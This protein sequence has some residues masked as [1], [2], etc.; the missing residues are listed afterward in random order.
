MQKNHVQERFSY[1]LLHH[2]YLPP[3]TVMVW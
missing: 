2:R 1:L 3:D